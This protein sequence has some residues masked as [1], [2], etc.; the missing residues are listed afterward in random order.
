MKNKLLLKGSLYGTKQIKKYDNPD[1][2]YSNVD[3]Q[4][5]QKN[6][7]TI[8]KNKDN[9]FYIY[10]SYVSFDDK[11]NVINSSRWYHTNYVLN[12]NSMN[13]KNKTITIILKNVNWENKKT[14]KISVKNVKIILYL[15]TIG[16]EKIQ[17]YLTSL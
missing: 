16:F 13:E 17:K 7:F 11:F 2:L 8:S 9:S 5:F 14:E 1:I 3:E 6:E 10:H 15:T 4:K 12:T